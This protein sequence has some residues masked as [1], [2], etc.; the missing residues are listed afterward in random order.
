VGFKDHFSGHAGDYARARPSYPQELFEYL[1]ANCECHEK[2]WDCG[3]GNGQAA[4]ALAKY[5]KQV[6]ATDA[7][8]SQISEAPSASNVE[9]RVLAAE[10][11]AL[12]SSS[13]DLVT[14]A[15]AL[16]WMDTDAFFRNADRV[17]KTDGRL[18]VWS[19]GLL[20]VNSYIDEIVGHLYEAILGDYWPEER[21]MV[22][23]EYA[24]IVFPFRQIQSRSFT[25]SLNWT[26]AELLDFLGSWSAVQRYKERNNADPL[27]LVADDLYVAWG[28]AELREVKWSL[29]LKLCSGGIPASTV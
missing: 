13:F 28:D 21:R 6:I 27:A 17:L 7:S 24:D 9:F 10:D 19:Y 11:P 15:Q 4:L 16:H 3:T 23:A 8:S 22:E 25:M 29:I 14:V 1:Q 12:E 2:V 20:K 18:A 26:L 5:F